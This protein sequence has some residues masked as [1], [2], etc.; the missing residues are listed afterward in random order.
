MSSV[1]SV[2]FQPYHPPPPDRSPFFLF[3]APQ[4][5]SYE[6][7]EVFNSLAAAAKARVAAIIEPHALEADTRAG[8]Q[9][10]SVVNIDIT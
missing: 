1:A 9:N 6:Q 3:F 10:L 4:M 7:W 8:K 2:V 5:Y